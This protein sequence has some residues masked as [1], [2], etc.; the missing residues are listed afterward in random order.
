MPRLFTEDTTTLSGGMN[1]KEHPLVIQPNQA[2]LIR[3]F[4]LSSAVMAKKRTGYQE[5]APNSSTTPSGRCWGIGSFEDAT[6]ITKYLIAAVGESFYRWGG[7]SQLERLG[8]GGECS[9]NGGVRF[10][11]GR[12]QGRARLYIV[13]PGGQTYEV[14]LTAGTLTPIASAPSGAVDGYYFMERMWVGTTSGE[15]HASDVGDPTTFVPGLSYQIGNSRPIKR[16]VPYMNNGFLVFKRESIWLA[17]IDLVNLFLFGYD[18]TTIYPVNTD[19]G[20]I[21]PESVQQAGEDYYFLSRHGVHTLKMTM[22]D[23]GIGIQLPISE[24]IEGTIARINW[25]YAD[26]A[27][28]VVWD[29]KYILA[30]PVDSSEWPNLI[31][32]YDM[33]TKGWSVLDGFSPTAMGIS[34]ADS[35]E[36][37]FFGNNTGKIYELFTR[38]DDDDATDISAEVVTRSFDFGTRTRE[39]LYMW[40][41]LVVEKNEGGSVD[42]SVN[43][44]G[45]GFSSLG[46]MD[47]TADLPVVTDAT[48]PNVLTLP[49]DLAGAGVVRERFHLDTL[50]PARSMQ[51]KLET[52][53]QNTVE[54]LHCSLSGYVYREQFE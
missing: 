44:D 40:F 22:Q 50:G 5:V 42:V 13:Q 29:N 31:L 48:S 10:I 18:Q 3:N 43:K 7:G 4:L 1:T 33:L 27:N 53:G 8:S 21:A 52:S 28:A 2:E 9:N 34:T 14:G 24:P 19:V 39:K 45:D 16:I 37:V 46:S 36:R 11:Q 47:L 51:F 17:N 20:T 32:V 41:E 6:L 15:I 25:R 23:R 30:V 38:R 26:R 35:Y 49:F 12:K 54:V